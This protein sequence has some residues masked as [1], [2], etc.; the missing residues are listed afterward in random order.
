MSDHP[1][2]VIVDVDGTLCD[3][4]GIL[5]YVD[6]TLGTTKS[7]KPIKN[8]DAFHAASQ[9][10][11]PNQQ[12]LDYVRHHHDNG[13]AIIIVTARM[14]QWRHTTTEW[15]K[16]TIPADIPW[17]LHMRPQ[18][19]YRKDTLVKTDIYN[20]LTDYGIEIIGAIDDNPAILAL[21]DSL[22]IP[23]EEVPRPAGDH[24]LDIEK[25]NQEGHGK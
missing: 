7:G 25:A 1:I 22:G 17:T 9:F 15:L 10:C 8:F 24:S 16:N 4:T 2:A 14:E 19:D 5:H 13:T 21:W 12:A 11:P 23:T 3:V 18:G 6:G 20:R